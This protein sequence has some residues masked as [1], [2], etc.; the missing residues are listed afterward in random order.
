MVA[1]ILY[2]VPTLG[3]LYAGPALGLCAVIAVWGLW[4]IVRE[5]LPT[6]EMLINYWN[7]NFKRYVALVVMFAFGIIVG[8]I[9][10]IPPDYAFWRAFAY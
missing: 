3:W 9:Y 4:P 2:F 6:R 7:E 5:R 8:G 1:L 10:G